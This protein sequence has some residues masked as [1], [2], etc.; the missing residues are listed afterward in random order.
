[1]GR[2]SRLQN[3][4][5]NVRHRPL[6]TREGLVGVQVFP[7]DFAE[8]VERPGIIPSAYLARAHWISLETE[9]ALIATEITRLLRR[10]YDLVLEKLPKKARAALA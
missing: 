3:R 7:E 2:R 8:L 1:V 6:G 5:Q 10:S 9:D 4:R